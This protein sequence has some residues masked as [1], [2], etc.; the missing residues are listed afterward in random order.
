ML[1]DALPLLL[2][3]CVAAPV[4][5]HLNVAAREEEELRIRAAEWLNCGPS[6]LRVTALPLLPDDVPGDWRAEVRCRGR[7]ASYRARERAGWVRE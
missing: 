2:I 1:R 6:E 3:A 4:V 5:P 7:V